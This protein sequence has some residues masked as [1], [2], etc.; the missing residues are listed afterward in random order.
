[1]DLFQTK[2]V[3]L[4]LLFMVRLLPLAGAQGD[5]SVELR[6]IDHFQELGSTLPIFHDTAGNISVEAVIGTAFP[7]TGI[8]AIQSRKVLEGSYYGKISLTN[9]EDRPVE[10][11]LYM[12]RALTYELYQLSDDRKTLTLMT[13]P[14]PYPSPVLYNEV[15]Y[16]PLVVPAH[17]TVTWLVH[18]DIH[19]YN[20]AFFDPVIVVPDHRLRFEFEHFMMPYRPYIFLSALQLGILLAIGLFALFR[21]LATGRSEYLYLS[22]ATLLF[23]ISFSMQVY[24]H[25]TFDKWFFYTDTFRTHILEF[26]GFSFLLLY[27]SR[28]LDLRQQQPDLSRMLKVLVG[29]MGLFI[30]ID[31][32]L[33]FSDSRQYMSLDSYY[34]MEIF[35]LCS[36]CYAV[37][38]GFRAASRVSWFMLAGTISFFVPI[39]IALWLSRTL[40]PGSL[41]ADAPNAI[42]MAGILFLLFNLLLGSGY[43]SKLIDIGRM[44]SIE[45]LRL[46]N[47]KGELERYRAAMEMR[48]KERHRIAQQIHDEIGSGLTSIRLHSEIA[49]RRKGND[50]KP[51]FAIISSTTDRLL[52][53]MNE[54]LWTLNIKNDSLSN[55]VSYLRHQIVQYCEP[56]HI[57]LRLIIPDDLPDLQVSGA[58]RRNILISVKEALHNIVDITHGDRVEIEFIADKQFTIIIRDN[59]RALGQAEDHG[60]ASGIRHLDERL[61]SVGGAYSAAEEGDSMQQLRVPLT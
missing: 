48:D 39:I 41:M 12:G 17:A 23:T 32:F 5:H 60:T 45:V 34:G 15:P 49:A 55:L 14:R 24:A 44:K 29:A 43:K 19:F 40:G 13:V 16:S 42:F 38:N 7:A 61:R 25:F 22:V 4:A 21:Y 3:L 18:P 6:S 1:M 2:T 20:K 35:L 36:A 10:M 50:W 53:K 30:L 27:A 31:L 59:G 47:E 46:E 56:H 52:D 51:D 26:G 58:V 8:K 11:L 57:H 9:S 33:A 28:L 54:I 37:L